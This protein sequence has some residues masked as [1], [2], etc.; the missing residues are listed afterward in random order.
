MTTPSFQKIVPRVENE[1]ERTPE[2]IAEKR[3]KRIWIICMC[4]IIVAGVIVA[5]NARSISRG[6][7]GWQA[8]RAAREA[9]K[10]LAAKD[11]KSAQ[12]KVQ[13]ALALSPQNPAA[14][15]TAAHFLTTAGAHKDAIAFW[16]KLEEKGPLS[17]ADQRQY[18]TSL[19][20]TGDLLQAG[21]H[22]K[23]SWPAGQPGQPDDWMLALNL[24]LQRRD[25]TAAVD[26]AQKLMASTSATA[27]Q[28]LKAA[29]L[30]TSSSNPGQR[31]EAW[32]LIETLS[33]DKT[34][35]GLEALVT[36]ARRAASVHSKQTPL[37][38]GETALSPQEVADAIEANPKAQA[39]H[40]LFAM[41]LRLLVEP[42][43]KAEMITS[44]EE[45]FTGN[46]DDLEA[47][48][49]WLYGKGE[50]RKVLVHLPADVAAHRRS[51]FLQSLDALAAMGRWKEVAGA[52]NG[53]SFALDKVTAEMYLAR[54]S[55]ELGETSGADSHWRTALDA[56][57]GNA[58]QLAL[59]ADY[60]ARA[61]NIAIAKAGFQAATEARDD[62]LPAYQ[63]LLAF[64]QAE[65][66]TTGLNTTLKRMSARWPDEAAVRN[67]LAY[68]DLLLQKNIE[69]ST[70]IAE[71]LFAKEPNSLPHR[72]TLSLAR[73]RTGNA[74][75]AAQVLDKLTGNLGPLEGRK[76]AVQAAALWANDQKS[77][78][79]SVLQD[80]KVDQL[81]PEERALVS[82]VQ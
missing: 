77:Q 2:E 30:M 32:K 26:L 7:K 66:D 39:K 65:G 42:L 53:A 5:F 4:V 45:K 60:A 17:P 24:A 76:R 41:D 22:A 34:E 73:L 35:T 6:I 20:A 15:L 61:G 16:V 11:Y 33:R 50:F 78:A 68:T 80:V 25:E 52:I 57:N 48:T 1:D 14:M 79:K 13:D 63:R 19:L 58:Q 64:A 47:L 27:D 18:A 71:Q 8:E 40:L 29:T 49:A 70:K 10:F 46:D 51:L 21:N 59:V 72:I 82:G 69:A 56:A 44:A 38:E 12:G 67:D 74:A 37:S 43:R 3:R 23:L 55:K 75:E 28:R 9:E 31:T 36:L 54:C 81:L 62:F